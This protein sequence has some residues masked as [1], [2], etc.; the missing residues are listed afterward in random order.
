MLQ[1][2][3]EKTA[4][5]AVVTDIGFG[6]AEILSIYE[7]RPNALASASIPDLSLETLA[8]RMA[9]AL[10]KQTGR[11]IKGIDLMSLLQ[12][13]NQNVIIGGETLDI[14]ELKQY[15]I[16]AIASS[17]TDEIIAL[18][19]QLPP[20]ARI[21]YYIFTGDGVDLFWKDLELILFQRNLIEDL[22]QA[23]HPKDYRISNAKGFEFIAR[24]RLAKTS[25]E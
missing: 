14:A 16:E 11:I 13:G 10:Q 17:L 15:Y 7:G 3:A 4:V 23:A 22:D 5:D 8:N 24:S 9:S 6:S 19:S 1:E 12:K 2:F 18:V 21:K 25:E 20:D